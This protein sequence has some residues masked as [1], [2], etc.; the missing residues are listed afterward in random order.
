LVL[1]VLEATTQVTGPDHF[2]EG[3]RLLAAS[4][5]TST[6]FKPDEARA[7]AA[8]SQAHFLAALTASHATAHH[9]ESVGWDHAIN[10]KEQP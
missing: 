10:P 4:E 3:E 6:A 7:L 9:P 8:Q 2:R 1:Q 5:D